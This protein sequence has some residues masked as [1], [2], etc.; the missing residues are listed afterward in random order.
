MTPAAHQLTH[1]AMTLHMEPAHQLLVAMVTI[2][3][4]VMVVAMA[5]I[6]QAM[7]ITAGTAETATSSRRRRKAAVRAACF[8][9]LLV[10]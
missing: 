6:L 9:A 8:S 3:I 10:A 1:A 4:R 5:A 2:M 7:E